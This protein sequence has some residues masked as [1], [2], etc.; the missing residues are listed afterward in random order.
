MSLTP[1]LI[2]L[3]LEG[4]EMAKVPPKAETKKPSK[5]DKAA[6]DKAKGTKKPG[7]KPGKTY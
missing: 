5:A 6:A 3:T 4:A 2:F 1:G 7:K